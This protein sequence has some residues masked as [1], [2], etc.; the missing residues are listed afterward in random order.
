MWF[1]DN[2]TAEHEIG[3]KEFLR[4]QSLS[5]WLYPEGDGQ[6]SFR[7]S[8]SLVARCEVGLFDISMPRFAFRVYL[9]PTKSS[10]INARRIETFAR[11]VNTWGLPPNHT[12]DKPESTSPKDIIKRSSCIGDSFLEP[13]KS[14]AEEGKYHVITTELGKA[15]GEGEKIEGT[16]F[17]NHMRLSGGACAQAVCFM[18]TALW[19]NIV[20]G[21]YGVAEI[22]ALASNQTGPSLDLGGIT[23]EKICV[24]FNH[25]KMGLNALRQ[26]VYIDT[27]PKEKTFQFADALRAYILSDIPVILVVD[28]GRMCGVEFN[29]SK[30]NNKEEKNQYI[31]ERNMLGPMLMGTIEK[32]RS[33]EI[34]PRFHAILIVGCE[35]TWDNDH[36]KPL[37]FVF[38]DPT[39]YPFLKANVDELVNARIY[40]EENKLE[41]GELCAVDFIA[42]SPREVRLPLMDIYKPPYSH[43]GLTNIALMAIDPSPFREL[44]KCA[45]PIGVEREEERAI[46]LVDLKCCEYVNVNE[47]ESQ[48]NKALA[49]LSPGAREKVLELVR[50]GKIYPKWCWINRG[51]SK[52]DIGKAI[53]SV[54]I[55]DATAPLLPHNAV[56]SNDHL[57]TKYLLAVIID[58]DGKWETIHLSPNLLKSAL[59]SSFMPKTI[60]D[61][62]QE[63]PQ[64]P[65]PAVD[66]YVF[67]QNEVIKWYDNKGEIHTPSITRDDHPVFIMSELADNEAA[68]DNWAE[69]VCESFRPGDE[70]M[71]II[72]ITSF[73]PE[74]TSPQQKTYEMAQKA[75]CFLVKFAYALQ[76]KG[77]DKLRT[78]EL[79]AGSQI[80]GVW[81][82]NNRLLATRVDAEKTHKSVLNIL[83]KA[84]SEYNN[85]SPEKRIALGLELEPGP[86][87]LLHDWQSL[88]DIC[89][90]IGNDN[91]LNKFVGVNLDIAH[92]RLAGDI[93]PELVWDAPAVRD[94]IVHAHIAG[95]QRCSHLADLPMDALNRHEDF[96]P[97]IDLLHRIST[98]WRDSNLPQFSGYVSLELEA[99]KDINLVKGSVEKLDSLL[100]KGKW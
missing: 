37:E 82:C 64:Y 19:H 15:Y 24:Y 66:L 74:V 87:Y 33:T 14:L 4:L 17:V 13:P 70:N 9:N 49:F 21:I 41:T 51:I 58:R 20:R 75:V 26:Q 83:R 32:C 42:V 98:D 63:W 90:K 47:I 76:Y 92:W 96:R 81:P 94:R 23:T 22:T 16:P 72:A 18:A 35:T 29:K 1:V 71:P 89:T 53:D 7:I 78:I 38:N 27:D 44:S 39:T 8:P 45:I 86:L 43:I 34:K 88:L 25:P 95:H 68:I 3:T 100:S 59:I 65:T 40:A 52:T 79:V 36:T 55:W 67:M 80:G 31:F 91:I 97:W 62:K 99:A 12:I 46:R 73:I 28:L 77:H 61:A 54:W 85:V 30:P 11:L 56:L 10:F 48:F 60:S 50:T 5:L 84:L 69:S 93:T 2:K 6:I 57:L